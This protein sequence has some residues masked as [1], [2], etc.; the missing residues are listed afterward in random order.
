MDLA[1][2]LFSAPCDNSAVAVVGVSWLDS[3]GSAVVFPSTAALSRC[4]F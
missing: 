3:P 4:L 1:G 2:Y